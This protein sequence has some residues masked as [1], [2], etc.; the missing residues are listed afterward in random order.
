M[1]SEIS[2]ITFFDSPER[3]PEEDVLK[4][5]LHFKQ[6]DLMN[7]LLEGYPEL[8]V[9]LNEHR[10]II[11]FNSKALKAF[12]TINY[13]DIVGKRVGEAINCIHSHANDSGC[14]TSRFCQYCGAAKAIKT[15]LEQQQS[16]S[17]ECRITTKLNGSEISLDL[18]VHTLPIK[19]EEKVYTLFT[20]QDISN[21]KR[22]SAL[23]RIFFHDILNTAAAL[24]GLT[25]ILTETE[26]NVERTQIQQDIYTSVS[27]LIDEIVSQRELRTA[28]DGNLQ[29]SFAQVSSKDI[30][31]NVMGL[32][33]KHELNKHKIFQVAISNQVELFVTD[34]ALLTRT[35]GNLVKNALEESDE[36]QKV[37]LFTELKDKTIFFHVASEKVIPEH[38]QLQLFQRSFSTKQGKG[39]GL[40]LYSVRLIAESV[41][42]GKVSFVSDNENKTVF[43][44]ELPIDQP[45]HHIDN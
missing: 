13:F 18:L 21:E 14:G 6:N 20:I 4:D 36:H 34:T 35:I 1:E 23:E 10:Q 32:Y 16:V 26:N 42:K 8:T 44:I 25:E 22:R 2:K 3:N 15:S 9:I 19:L 39:R 41:L 17:E 45:L 28:E 27:Q 24:R 38:I 31:E 12:H 40:G 33:G 7:Q 11:A 43:T 29:P 5:I 37:R 30:L